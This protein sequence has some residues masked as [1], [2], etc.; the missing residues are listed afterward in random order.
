MGSSPPPPHHHPP[1]SHLEQDVLVTVLVQHVGLVAHIDALL[2]QSC[3]AR[4]LLLLQDA[5]LVLDLLQ[6]IELL[7]LQLVQLRDDVGQGALNA[8]NDDCKEERERD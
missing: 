4:L 5:L 3:P 1:H 2:Q 8:R 6:A 7:S